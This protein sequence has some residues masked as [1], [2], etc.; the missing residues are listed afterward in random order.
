MIRPFKHPHRAGLAFALVFAGIA[1]A[2]FAADD[3][4]PLSDC[5]IEAG[6]PCAACHQEQPPSKAVA[7]ATCL[8]CH[9]PQDKLLDRSAALQPNPHNWPAGAMTCETCHRAHPE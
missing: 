7:S 5:H 6:L 3:A 1:G 4:K 2:A 8:M 9:G